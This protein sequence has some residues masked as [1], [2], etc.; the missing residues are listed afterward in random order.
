MVSISRTSLLVFLSFIFVCQSKAGPSAE[1]R[2]IVAVF[3]IEG[4][5]KG[6]RRDLMLNLTEYLGAKLAEGGYQIIPHDQIRKRL[7]DQKKKS[8][9]K[10]VD[11]SCQIE[12]GREM[13]AQKSLS[14]KI[15]RIGR[16][17]KVTATL[18]D[19]KRSAAELAATAS[20]SCNEDAL[21]EAIEKV[22]DKLCEPLRKKEKKSQEALSDFDSVLKDVKKIQAKKDRTKKAWATVSKMVGDP[23]LAVSTKSQL[24]TKFL[25]EFEGDNPYEEEARRLFRE[26]VPGT[27]AVET[28]PQG[29][30]IKKP[31]SSQLTLDVDFSF[32]GGLLLGPPTDEGQAGGR[33]SVG[34][35]AFKGF[36]VGI[37]MPFYFS[38][39]W[40]IQGLLSL[41]YT[42]DTTTGFFPLVGLAFGLGHNATNGFSD[43]SFALQVEAG[44]KYLL[45]K[46]GLIKLGVVYNQS[47]VLDRINFELG[48]VYWF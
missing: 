10:C 7:M 33:L 17:C 41:S 30:I 23:S 40:G 1:D 26:I 24:L 5:G 21:S 44:C 42:W 20:S 27:L 13:A 39:V 31:Y 47:S 34:L 32:G 14:S 16:K 12:L 4:R 48:Y 29:A 9:K 43:T 2:P 15:L 11:Q 19:L 6:L 35:Y 36:Q 18:Y 8:Y 37:Q 25:G 22:S 3:E 46:N 28:D 38:T 45:G